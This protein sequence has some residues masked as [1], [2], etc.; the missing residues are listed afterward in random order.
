VVPAER[1][2]ACREEGMVVLWAR[3]RMKPRRISGPSGSPSCWAAQETRLL[4]GS[5][6]V[7]LE[8]SAEARSLI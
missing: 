2:L 3:N 4:L 7:A 1:V 5:G 8:G 6:V